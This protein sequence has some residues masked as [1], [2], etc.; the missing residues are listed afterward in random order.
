MAI[1]ATTNWVAVPKLG[2][3]YTLD[4]AISEV[5]VVSGQLD[6]ELVPRRSVA[7]HLS[8]A[9][10][11]VA[12]LLNTL[13]APWYGID[14]PIHPDL[15]WL[16]GGG[17]SDIS[18][19]NNGVYAT[20]GIQFNYYLNDFNE[21][22]SNQTTSV[23]QT[24]LATDGSQ[25]QF[26][27]EMQ[28]FLNPGSFGESIGPYTT[29]ANT[30]GAARFLPRPWVVGVTLATDQPGLDKIVAL[31]IPYQRRIGTIKQCR[32]ISQFWGIAKGGNL[33]WQN[34]VVWVQ[35]GNQLRLWL[36]AGSPNNTMIIDSNTTP[37]TD[38]I[39]VHAY[40][41]A[42]PLDPGNPNDFMDI[43][44]KYASLVIN[45][46]SILCMKQ[47]KMGNYENVAGEVNQQ[48]QQLTAEYEKD[49]ARA[50]QASQMEAIQKV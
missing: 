27:T 40:R 50:M 26:I 39:I 15:D 30:G 36:G 35:T 34:S 37:P 20:T 5:Q 43:P 38:T 29:F 32:D 8:I 45:K 16:G 6:P 28:P 21:P 47:A 17:P 25:G 1:N 4:R 23:Q 3:I 10:Y 33:Q 19:I 11:E 49:M 2:T 9:C 14:L 24:A 48:V 31:S 46:A 41:H 44:D 13:C 12:S 42:A 7:E 18:I 22:D